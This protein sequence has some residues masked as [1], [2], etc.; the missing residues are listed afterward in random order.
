MKEYPL[1]DNL[2]QRLVLGA[3]EVMKTSEENSPNSQVEHEFQI[4]GRTM[5]ASIKI[6]EVPKVKAYR[7][8]D[9]LY[10]EYTTKGRTMQ[11]IAD[12]FSITPMSIHQ[13]LKKLGI[14]TRPRGR[15][16]T[17]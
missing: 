3:I 14:E 9:W 16:K 11:D 6:A 5:I 10:E 1:S 12:Q 15:F 13:W 8:R 17:E 4:D 2:R 7:S